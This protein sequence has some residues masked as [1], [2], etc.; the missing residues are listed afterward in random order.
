M[1]VKDY[2]CDNS[3]IALFP[4]NLSQNNFSSI[5]HPQSCHHNTLVNTLHVLQLL[6]LLNHDRPRC[7]VDE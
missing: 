7:L 3:G 6:V 2:L 4:L 1:L 5:I